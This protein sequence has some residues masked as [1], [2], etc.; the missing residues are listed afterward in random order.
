[1]E[2]TREQRSDDGSSVEHGD[3]EEGGVRLAGANSRPMAEASELQGD[4]KAKVNDDYEG[5]AARVRDLEMQNET[6]TEN[7]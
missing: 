6:L 7:L 5:S 1:M 4:P 2:E 3:M